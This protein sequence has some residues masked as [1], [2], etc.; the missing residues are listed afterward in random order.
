MKIFVAPIQGHTDAAWRNFHHK[1]YG[2]EL[3]YFTPFIRNEHG[4]LRPKDLKELTHPLNDEMDLEPQIIFRNAEELEVLLKMVVESGKRSVNLNLGCPFPPQTAKGRGAG[5]ISN[6]TEAEKMRD[7]LADFP[8]VRFSVK[9]RL[10]MEDPDEWRGVLEILNTIPLDNIY[11]H[12]RVARQQYG[13]ELYLDRFARIL[14]ASRNPVVFNG[15]IKAPEDAK[16]IVEK[17]PKING[18]MIGRGILARPSLAVE[19]E[20]GE[21][22][23]EKRVEKMMD[24]HRELFK[25]YRETLCGDSQ[26]LS[27]I[28]PFWEYA[29][30]EIGRKAWKTIKK[31]ATI[32]KYNAAVTLIE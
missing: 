29:E 6:L 25:Y 7:I 23:R 14:E 24:F 17:F 21:W 15:E 18:I 11:V 16:G 28:K 22:P 3:R 19:I 27:K 2:G 30:E 32:P 1:V 13:G 10:G 26:I 31:A 5:F 12:P 20:E 4:G 9:M 8:D